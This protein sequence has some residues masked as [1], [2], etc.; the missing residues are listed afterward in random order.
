[1]KKTYPDDLLL[2][3]LSLAFELKETVDIEQSKGYE[4]EMV[5]QSSRSVWE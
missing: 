3:L 1:M 5:S 2:A 4:E